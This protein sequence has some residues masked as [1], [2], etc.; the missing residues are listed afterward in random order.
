MN[1]GSA[2]DSIF[3]D[4]SRINLFNVAPISNSLS[5]H[6]PQFIVLKK[7]FID[8]EIFL[9][10]RSRY[11]NKYSIE[12]FIDIIRNE[13]WE[14]TYSMNQV[15]DIFNAC[16][17]TFLIHFESCFPV[18]YVTRKHKSNDWITTGIRT[19]S[20]RKGILYIFSKISNCPVIK[21]F[22]HYY[23]SILTLRRLMSYI[24]IYIYGA[25]ILDVSRSHTMTQHSR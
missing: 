7:M 21:Y 19:S 11:I 23:C 8:S 5:D 4:G 17:N 9:S 18:Y 2:I 22:S 1:S 6:E 16:L 10:H 15:N 20:K 14:N 13:K 12:N 24:Y 25:P 3:I